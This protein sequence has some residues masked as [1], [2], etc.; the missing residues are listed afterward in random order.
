MHNIKLIID[1]L[2][3]YINWNSFNIER[4]SINNLVA[5]FLVI[6]SKSSAYQNKFF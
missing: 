3:K 5:R 4:Q 1:K 2:E 6:S